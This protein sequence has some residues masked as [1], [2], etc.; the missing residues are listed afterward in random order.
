MNGNNSFM[1]KLKHD[2]LSAL[3]EDEEFKKKIQRKLGMST[4]TMPF[5]R[6]EG[7][8][9]EKI[10]TAISELDFDKVRKI[11]SVIADCDESFLLSD[12]EKCKETLKNQLNACFDILFREF[13]NVTAHY[14]NIGG[15]CYSYSLDGLFNTSAEYYMLDD[16][17]W[18][19]SVI[20]KFCPV[21]Y[22]EL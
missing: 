14:H 13:P 11:A 3:G 9:K 2:F 10:E 21:E 4:S 18:E 16:G 19:P 12:E 1:N 5:V 17:K 6:D 8:E 15:N 20:I 7:K 22:F